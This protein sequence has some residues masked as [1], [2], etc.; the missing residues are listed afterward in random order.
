MKHTTITDGARPEHSMLAS[1]NYSLLAPTGTAVDP[2][3][4]GEPGSADGY[5]VTREQAKD[6]GRETQEEDETQQHALPARGMQGDRYEGGGPP[7]W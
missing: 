6:D 4:A 5:E 3:D 2:D 7:E 1:R